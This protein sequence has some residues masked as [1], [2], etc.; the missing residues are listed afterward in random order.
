MKTRE[1]T[2]VKEAPRPKER[3]N[4]IKMDSETNAWFKDHPGAQTTVMC[5]EKCGLWYKPDLGHECKVKG[6]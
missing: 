2:H 4:R 5:C 1:L 3:L 6:E